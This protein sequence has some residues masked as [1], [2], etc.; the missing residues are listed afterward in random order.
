MGAV[1]IYSSSPFQRIWQI[2]TDLFAVAAIV[3]AWLLSRAT[4]D[5]VSNL[6]VFGRSMEDA[7]NQFR[8]TMSDAAAGIGGV[9]L[10]GDQAS[11]PF[12]D[13]AEAGGFLIAAGQDQQDSVAQAAELVG[14]TIFL[15]PILVLIPM[16][17]IPRVRF[18]VRSMRTRRLHEGDGGRELLALRALVL[19][20]PAQL[21]KV[22]EDPVRAWR[23][24]DAA[25]V[26]G[27]ARL[28]LKQA[29][30]RAK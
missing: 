29:G 18:V 4:F 6:A 30:V 14:W 21:R 2:L 19:A 25:A 15:L 17:L 27:L 3:V 7:G 13:A 20:N 1:Q 22:S 11:A 28:A 16:W 5:A 9:P 10:I 23:E 24:G 8:S 12:R 26:D